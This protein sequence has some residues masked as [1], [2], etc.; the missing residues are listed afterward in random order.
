MKKLSTY[1]FISILFLMHTLTVVAATLS[2]EEFISA[3]KNKDYIVY[4]VDTLKVINCAPKIKNPDKSLRKIKFSDND[5]HQVIFSG[6]FTFKNIPTASIIRNGVLDGLGGKKSNKRGGLAILND[7]TIIIGRTNGQTLE[8]VNQNFSRNGIAVRD[9]MGGGALL[10][11]N[12]ITLSS[13]DDLFCIQQF[14]QGGKGIKCGQMRKTNHLLFIERDDIIYAV[15]AKNKKGKT[16]VLDL[17][18]LGID[19]LIKYDGGSGIYVRDNKNKEIKYEGYNST[20]FLATI[21]QES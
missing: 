5:K 18:N 16:I 2:D 4:K 14:D 7:N 20:G 11:E 21:I 15:I 8:E 19:N 13:L 9:F 1:F 12:G 3:L 6:T 17:E 10:I